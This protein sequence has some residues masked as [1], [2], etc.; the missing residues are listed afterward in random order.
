MLELPTPWSIAGQM[1]VSRAR[2]RTSDRRLAYLFG[3]T[4]AGVR[5][6]LKLKEA[7]G[8]ALLGM[9]EEQLNKIVKDHKPWQELFP[10]YAQAAKEASQERAQEEQYQ[11]ALQDHLTKA[12]RQFKKQYKPTQG[13]NGKATKRTVR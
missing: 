1:L 8:A 11:R 12:G 2:N 10:Q 9:D 4:P 13:K 6:L 5:K 3:S 7:V